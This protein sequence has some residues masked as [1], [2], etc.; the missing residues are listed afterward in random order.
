MHFIGVLFT[1]EMAHVAQAT[2]NNVAQML[3]ERKFMGLALRGKTA[4]AC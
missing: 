2:A 1:P 4:G 3:A